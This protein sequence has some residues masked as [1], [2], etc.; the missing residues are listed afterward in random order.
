MSQDTTT[1]VEDLPEELAR[2]GQV[3]E[4]GKVLERQLRI[5]VPVKQISG[6]SVGS[7]RSSLLSEVRVGGSLGRRVA[8]CRM[9]RW[10]MV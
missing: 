1:G 7:R 9:V 8:G 3:G 2:V 6:A 10:M 4:V 5:R